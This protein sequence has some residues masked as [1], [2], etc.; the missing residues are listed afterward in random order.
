MR[1]ERRGPTGHE[2]PVVV[3]DQV[4]FDL[5]PFTDDIDGAFFG[6]GGIE[7]TRAALE[8]GRLS[9]IDVK[10]LRVGA[11]VTRPSAIVC[12]G[13]N[14]AAHAA[15]TGDPPP[16]E[17]IVFLKH[18]NTIIGPFDDVLRPPG[19]N[20]LDW[21]VELAV[22]VGK[23]A[24]YLPDEAA[25]LDCVAGYT[26]SNDVT[27]RTFQFERSGGQWS[28]GKCCESFNPLGPSLIPAD[29]I[30]NVQEL[31][32]RSWVNREPRQDSSTAD[33]IFGV[34]ALVMHLSQFMVLEPGD[35]INTG[36]PKG[37]AASGRFPYLRRGD[38]IRL[39]IDEIGEQRQTVC[40]PDVR[41]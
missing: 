14:Y 28:K 31:R 29:E 25:A 27:E 4:A 6:A 2:M 11:P 12:I 8:Q 24:R 16:K 15:E 20:T 9:P 18:P 40:D 3:Q 37:V 38:E 33:M 7:R 1:F 36:T 13:Q 21:E 30:S 17:P 19:A 41:K 26:I 23:S 32:L 39:S 35:V 34:G 5:R 10:G 22:V